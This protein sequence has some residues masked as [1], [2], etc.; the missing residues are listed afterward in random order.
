MSIFIDPP[1]WPAHGTVFS[2]L[3][4]DTSLAE[5]HDFAA[6]TGISPRAF[7]ADHYDVPAYRYEGLVRAGAREVSGS[8]LTRIL[9][10][11]G[12]RVPLRERPNKI[13][14]R[15]M[16]AWDSLLPGHTALGEDLL[17]RY[18]QPHRKYHTSVHL[19]E[20]LTAL[21]TLYKR[22]HTATPRAVLLAA[23]F[24]DAV[25][26]ANPGDDEAASADLARTALTPLASTGFLTNRGV[27]A[28]AHLIELT[29]SHQLADGIE[30]Y[31]SGAL[32]RADAE[33]FLDADLA[34]LA[35][36]SPRYTRYVAGVRAEYAHYAPDA[37]TRGRAAILQGFL[38]RTAIYAS[39]TAH[40]LWDAPARLNL[41]TELEGYRAALGEQPAKEGALNCARR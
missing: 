5:L 6:K 2:H 10:D 3:I 19:S 12:L 30:E 16:R 23:W 9:I 32:T 8:Q 31:T 15:L 24:H 39:D 35:A 11:S 37:F 27:T 17:E 34:I 29:A 26:E 28:I 20:M 18:E 25:Y 33:F 4:S 41:R 36:D 13:R 1:V 38:N 22:H 40:L 7:D 14:P 21:K